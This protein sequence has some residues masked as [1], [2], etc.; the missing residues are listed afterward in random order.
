MAEGVALTAAEGLLIV[1]MVAGTAYRRP[2]SPWFW[3][4][5]P[6]TCLAVV[7]LLHRLLP[8]SPISAAYGWTVYLPLPGSAFLGPSLWEPV[9]WSAVFCGGVL[10]SVRAWRRGSVEE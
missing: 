4:V 6:V 7:F 9:V 8:V 10:A 1:V 3:V 5:F 2:A